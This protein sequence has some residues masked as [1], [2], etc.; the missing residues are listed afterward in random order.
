M[1][2]REIFPCAKRRRQPGR[3]SKR[4]R[5]YPTVRSFAPTVR[6]LCEVSLC[7]AIGCIRSDLRIGH[8]E[9]RC[10]ITMSV[11]RQFSASRYS[12]EKPTEF[13]SQDRYF[14][15]ISAPRVQA[16]FSPK[17]RV[18]RCFLVAI[19]LLTHRVTIHRQWSKSK[20]DSQNQTFTSLEA[21]FLKHGF[22][23]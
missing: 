19:A 4:S 7:E 16:S 2:A 9:S 3:K 18:S 15:S 10:S 6:K 5:P 13:I 11:S 23:V 12:A 1:L 21:L 8:A 22:C 20:K 14:V 17:C